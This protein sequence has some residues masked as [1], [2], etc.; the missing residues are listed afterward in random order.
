MGIEFVNPTETERLPLTDGAWIEVRNR[1]TYGA[2]QR[3]DSVSIR[4]MSSEAGDGGGT[5]ID[6]DMS[7]FKIERMAA[8]IVAWSVPAKPD[9]DAFS[10]LREESAEEIN[11]ALDA[12]IER[13]AQKASAAEGN[14]TVTPIESSSRSADG[15]VGAELR[16]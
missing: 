10:A 2:K 16:Y 13:Q 4:T 14:P 11:A 9:R 6:I 15:P 12:H 7:V 3:L 8:Y 1:I 5:K